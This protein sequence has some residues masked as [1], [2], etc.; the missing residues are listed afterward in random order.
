MEVKIEKYI[1]TGQDVLYFLNSI[2]LIHSM[3]EMYNGKDIAIMVSNSMY[4]NMTTQLFRLLYILTKET[5]TG[6]RV[7]YEK[8][9]SDFSEISPINLY[10]G[11]SLKAL[12]DLSAN[13]GGGKEIEQ[14][15]SKLIERGKLIGLKHL[16]LEEYNTYI[17]DIPVDYKTITQQMIN[18]VPLSLRM[19]MGIYNIISKVPLLKSKGQEVK[20]SLGEGGSYL[21]LDPSIIPSGI[22]SITCVSWGWYGETTKKSKNI[23]NIS[24][25]VY[26]QVKKEAQDI[27]KLDYGIG[28]FYQFIPYD[29]VLNGDATLV[30]QY[31]DEEVKNIDKSQLGIYYEDKDNHKWVY[32]GGIVDSVNKQVVAPIKKL[33]L[34]TIA[35][36]IPDGEIKLTPTKD[37]IS[38]DETTTTLI[39]SDTIYYNNS[40][41]I[42]N[43]ELFTVSTNNGEILNEDLDDKTEGIQIHPTSGILKIT[44]KSSKIGGI[45]TIHVS[46]VKGY[47]EGQTR[48]F[49]KDNIAPSIPFLTKIVG[50]NN[51]IQ[52]YWKPVPD[53]DLA[54]YK[55]YFDT[56]SLAPYDG[57]AKIQGL[58]S[59]IVIGK[60]TGY[61]ITGLFEDSTYYVVVTAFD[62][63]NNESGYSNILSTNLITNSKPVISNQEVTFKGLCN[64]NI[65]LDTIIASDPDGDSLLYS[66][67]GGKN[68]ELFGIDPESGVLSLKTN[69]ML[70]D[71]IQELLIQ[72]KDY[73][74]GNLMSFAFVKIKTYC[75][76]NHP[77]ILEDK[78]FEVA[79]TSL[80]NGFKI[81]KIQASDEDPGQSLTYHILEQ[82]SNQAVSIDT[83]TG[84]LYITN[85]DSLGSYVNKTYL[86]NVLVKDDGEGNLSVNNVFKIIIKQVNTLT[87]YTTTGMEISDGDTI[88]VSH[89]S[90]SLMM[91]IKTIADNWCI[92]DNSLWLSG[93]KNNDTLINISYTENI[94]CNERNATVTVSNSDGKEIHLVIN[95][96]VDASTCI[97]SVDNEILSE[98]GMYPNPAHHLVYLSLGNRTY[99]NLTVLVKNA[100][101][102]ILII[103]RYTYTKSNE[104]VKIDMDHIAS[105]LYFIQVVSDNAEKTMKLIVQNP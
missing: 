28:G 35:P 3:E 4:G 18:D 77:P 70:Y 44:L 9:R 29:S 59:P 40:T 98:I 34:Y 17:K 65:K 52:L 42:S 76:Q 23:N 46:S 43:N 66:I 54:G 68:S 104:I 82:S 94:T 89:N 53:I 55:I 37:T 79:D 11:F 75:A 51:S 67:N 39:V 32:V 71:T 101:G 38:A 13:I 41:L 72:V 100:I 25:K 15:K 78:S 1:I 62:I 58:P 91:H 5:S 33:M 83:I 103:R 57:I 26:N 102:R 7:S 21:L 90:G 6:I 50:V 87:L 99:K 73:G 105:G 95:Q 96:G 22:D 84:E 81:G 47:A 92:S 85:A 14:G 93:L 8:Y 64:N 31:Q 63:N 16:P 69:E 56:D 97:S 19:M 88:H 36:A 24:Y 80:K 12:A 20:Y 30:I 86:L 10:I 45:S 60:D 27:Y 74:P 61:V 2:D 49:F 48:L